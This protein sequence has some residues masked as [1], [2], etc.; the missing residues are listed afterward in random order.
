MNSSIESNPLRLERIVIGVDFRA[1]SIAAVRSC[2]D[3]FGMDAELVLAHSVGDLDASPLANACAS[4]T[5][6]RAWRT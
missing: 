2:A 3:R 5:A 6:S 1:P 4:A